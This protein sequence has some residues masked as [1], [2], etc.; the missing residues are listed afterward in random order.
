M[1]RYY[2]QHNQM[3]CDGDP[4]TFWQSPNVGGSFDP[5]GICIHYTA[6]RL[7]AGSAANWMRDP[8]A[9]VSAH[10][11]VEMDAE[12]L[13]LV[14]LNQRAWHAGISRFQGQG[15]CNDRFFGI[16][17]VNPGKLEKVGTNTYQSWFGEEYNATEYKIRYSD[18]E[19][20]GAVEVG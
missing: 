16:E 3:I 13:Q 19:E 1:S 17:V 9:K 4:V 20:F 8:D 12:P 15:N 10:F 11:T 18:T 6:S 7:D 5:V 14:H 2:V